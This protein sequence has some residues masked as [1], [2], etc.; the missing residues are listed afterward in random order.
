MTKTVA[1]DQRLFEKLVATASLALLVS[2]LFLMAP[3]GARADINPTNQGIAAGVT[4]RLYHAGIFKHGA[5]KV[6]VAN[7]VATLTGTVDSYGQEL[8]AV[9]EARPQKGVRSVVDNIQVSTEGVG[10]QQ[11]LA[12]ARHS[13]LM[14]PFYTIFDHITLKAEGNRLVVA[15][16]VTHPFMKSDLGNILA[17][18]RGVTYLE[19]DI[20]V[21]PVSGMDDQ[22]RVAVAIGIYRDPLFVNYANQA[23][24]PIHIVVDH[25]NVTLYGAVD[26]NV[27]RQKAEID[28]RFATT[29]LGLKNELRIVA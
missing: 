8:R 22:I 25:G 13:V 27:L 17:G 11:I 2:L 9:K 20:R 5:V 3:A 16:E 28:A 19:N 6:D 18:I 23:N 7:G 14:Y 15:G 21:L 26:S 1:F 24:P 4:S 29:Y 12:Q 10:P